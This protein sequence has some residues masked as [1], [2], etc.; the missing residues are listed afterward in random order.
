LRCSG[1]AAFVEKALFVIP[2]KAFFV[3]PAK[4]FFVIPAK[5]FFVIPAKAFFVI[6]AKAGTPSLKRNFYLSDSKSKTFQ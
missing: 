2:A 3:I 5:A 4:A 1:I 6:P